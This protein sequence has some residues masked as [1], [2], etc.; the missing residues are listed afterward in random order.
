MRLF[1]AIELPGAAIKALQDAQETLLRTAM[2]AMK[3]AF[4]QL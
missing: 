2:H 4:C 1:V 3:Q